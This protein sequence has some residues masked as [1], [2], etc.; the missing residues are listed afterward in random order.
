MH[1]QLP[2]RHSS[3]LPT[4]S[5]SDPLS[6]RER[7]SASSHFREIEQI[8]ALTP[9]KSHLPSQTKVEPFTSP[10]TEINLKHHTES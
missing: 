5:H 4:R 9:A 7:N 8:A 1:R 2:K 6:P 10:L 3:P